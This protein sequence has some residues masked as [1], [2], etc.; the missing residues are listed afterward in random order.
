VGKRNEQ[1][2][3]PLPLRHQLQSFVHNHNHIYTIP[4]NLRVPL[5]AQNPKPRS[6][7][8]LL[9]YVLYTPKLHTKGVAHFLSVCAQSPWPLWNH[10]SLT[11]HAS[12]E[13]PRNP[14]FLEERSQNN[15][16]RNHKNAH[17]RLRR[18]WCGCD[19]HSRRL[20][21]ITLIMSGGLYDLRD[22]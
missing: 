6:T 7:R 18:S 2:G 10:K 15:P 8:H 13:T 5:S 20:A 21:P 1:D 3:P 17:S 4:K 9:R 22:N 11:A 12:L 19:R 16:H 14:Q